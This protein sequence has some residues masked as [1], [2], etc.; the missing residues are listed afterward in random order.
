MHKVFS[1]ESSE[2]RSRGKAS[3]VLCHGCCLGL[4]VV[5]SIFVLLVVSASFG[6][7]VENFLDSYTQPEKLD[8]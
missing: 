5:F 7:L 6:G 2:L 8:V 3:V 1:A 4:F